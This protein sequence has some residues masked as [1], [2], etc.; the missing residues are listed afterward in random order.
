MGEQL[1]L[2]A[3]VCGGLMLAA[4]L[5]DEGPLPAL[6]AATLV[7]AWL[8]NLP[9]S[10]AGDEGARERAGVAVSILAAP[11]GS[12]V[13]AS[14]GWRAAALLALGVCLAVAWTVGVRMG[15]AVVRWSA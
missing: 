2:C 5:A 12:L 11:V 15:R 8:W 6:S 7:C 13:G 10:A 9:P 3:G 4:A 14:I 1:G